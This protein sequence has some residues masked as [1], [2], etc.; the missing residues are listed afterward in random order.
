MHSRQAC[1]LCRNPCNI[2]SAIPNVLLKSMV[3]KLY[4][5]CENSDK[6]CDGV[7]RVENLEKHEVNCPSIRMNSLLKENAQLRERISKLSQPTARTGF[8]VVVEDHRP[9]TVNVI[10]ILYIV[11][12]TILSKLFPGF[13]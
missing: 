2:S 3:Q 12:D 9:K 4:I 7:V 13:Y 11:V 6:G 10:F 1:P 8:A 5:R